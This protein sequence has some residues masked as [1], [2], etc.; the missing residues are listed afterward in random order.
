MDFPLSFWLKSRYFHLEERA[1]LGLLGALSKDVEARVDWRGGNEEFEQ[2]PKSMGEEAMASGP[3]RRQ[4]KDRL[5]LKHA[6]EALTGQKGRG[7]ATFFNA[8]TEP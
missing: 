6:L 5:L 3:G 8:E 1:G 4:G 2:D 7:T